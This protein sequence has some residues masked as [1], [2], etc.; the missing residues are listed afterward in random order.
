MEKPTFLIATA[1]PLSSN[2][3]YGGSLMVEVP[4]EPSN[5]PIFL[6][7]EGSKLPVEDSCNRLRAGLGFSIKGD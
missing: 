4:Y 6:D 2:G 1:T 3:L 7:R 5:S